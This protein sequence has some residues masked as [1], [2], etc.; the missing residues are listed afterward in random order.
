MIPER[1]AIVIK[2]VSIQNRDGDH[3]KVTDFKFSAVCDLG[4]VLKTTFRTVSDEMDFE[5]KQRYHK[6]KT[7]SSPQIFLRRSP[8]SPEAFI[9]RS[10]QITCKS[11]FIT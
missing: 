6:Q 7:P 11:S 4:T 9:L 10:L 1:R 5:G 8:T 3:L 2:H